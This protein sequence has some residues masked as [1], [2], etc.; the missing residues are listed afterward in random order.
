M[1]YTRQDRE[2]LRGEWEFMQAGVLRPGWGKHDHLPGEVDLAP[3]QL[4]DL[5]SAL[6]GEE[7]QAHDV[8]EVPIT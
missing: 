8:C 7:E 1:R 3:L 5:V 4:A 6:A 2:G